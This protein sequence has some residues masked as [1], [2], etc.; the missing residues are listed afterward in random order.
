[1]STQPP[2]AYVGVIVNPSVRRAA[3]DQCHTQKL[4]CTKL[5][6]C[7]V[8]VR[9]QRL[10][11]Q[12][13]WSPPSRSG[14]PVRTTAKD[15]LMR[16]SGRSELTA[17]EK[18][19]KRSSNIPD[20]TPE[21]S[22]H[23]AGAREHVHSN[24]DNTLTPPSPSPPVGIAEVPPSSRPL[25]IAE[26]NMSDIFTFPSPRDSSRENLFPPWWVSDSVVPSMP[27]LTECFQLPVNGSASL[28]D[29]PGIPEDRSAPSGLESL[30]DIT[31]ELS[32]VNLSLLDLEQSLHAKPWGPMFASPAAVITKLSACGSSDQLDGTLA[33]GYPLIEIFKHTQRFIDIAKQTSVYFASLPT[34]SA[35]TSTSSSTGQ[36]PSHP[37]SN[38]TSS[39]GSSSFSPP[40]DGHLPYTASLTSTT[41]GDRPTRTISC[42][43]SPT[44]LL[45]TAGYARI[46]DIYL[47]VLTQTS[48]FVHALSMQSRS[49]G[50][51]YRQRMHP[52]IPPLQWGGFRPANYG[53]L[54]ILMILQV[55]SYLLT[56]VERALGVD[57]WEHEVMARERSQS[58]ERRSHFYPQVHGQSCRS[59]DFEGV[60]VVRAGGRLLSPAMIELVAQGEESGNNDCQRGKIGVLRR[61]LRQLK[62][63][64]ENSMHI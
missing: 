14:R 2:S 6:D 57:E 12:C 50:P 64:I 47:T 34:T 33:H 39:Q 10:N 7:L 42:R 15:T 9:C 32:N 44:A 62:E 63:E 19:G 59:D 54:Q 4:R 56:E 25:S 35:S 45:F 18:R 46:L 55:I 3:C 28:G 61:E 17:R 51:D 58:A 37:D 11:R 27:N 48:H 40:G 26:W 36:P 5:E 22:G 38:D 20:M 49:G 31:R 53:A 23:S 41:R 16:R 24:P 30:R 21:E 1:M 43:D 13:I 52:V 29:Q 60:R 8:C